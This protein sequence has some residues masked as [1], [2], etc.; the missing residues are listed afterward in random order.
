M[1]KALKDRIIIKITESDNNIIIGMEQKT[2]NT[3][4]VLSVGDEVKSVKAGE[5]IIFHLYDEI[6]L[7]QKSLAVIREKSVLA[8]II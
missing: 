8:K 6:E 3:G 7:P 4:V 5:H 2:E 1:Y